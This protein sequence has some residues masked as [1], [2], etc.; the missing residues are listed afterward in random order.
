M[1]VLKFISVGL[2]VVG[3]VGLFCFIVDAFCD[4]L[5]WLVKF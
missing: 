2:L 1:S 4:A 5:D 3:V